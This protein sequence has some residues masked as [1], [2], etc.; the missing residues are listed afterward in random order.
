MARTDQERFNES[1]LYLSGVDVQLADDVNHKI[2]N[3]ALAGQQISLGGA[4]YWHSGTPEQHQAVRA[5]LLCVIAYLRAPHA[6]QINI[7]QAGLDRLR[8]SFRSKSV[9]QVNQEILCFVRKNGA[10]LADLASA[11]TRIC[12]PTGT[13]DVLARTRTDDNVGAGP[14][15]YNG[16]KTWLFA[17]GFVSKRWLAK[18]GQQLDGNCANRYLGDGVEL[19]PD[20]WDNIPLGYMWN[21]HKKGDKTTCHWGVS[22]GDNNAVACNNTD[23]SPNPE[24]GVYMLQYETGTNSAYGK[25]KFTDICKVCN[26]NFK[27]QGVDGKNDPSGYNIVVR[28]IDPRAVTTFY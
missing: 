18:E 13:V 1:I 12:H 5:F 3:K 6:H 9:Q 24:G 25:F 22:L 28:Q 23:G 26:W 10:S 4:G 17:A 11:S 7:D 15:C 16:V 27:Y 2:T 8:N 21:I 20:G 14:V 19:Q